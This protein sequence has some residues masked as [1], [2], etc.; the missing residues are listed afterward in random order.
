MKAVEIIFKKCHISLRNVID[1]YCY[2]NPSDPDIIFNTC[3]PRGGVI[4]PPLVKSIFTIEMHVFSLFCEI[5][6]KLCYILRSINKIFSYFDE[7][8]HF[9]G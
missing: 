1:F 6:Q 7:F 3:L 9:V 8:L 2:F 4:T 5:L